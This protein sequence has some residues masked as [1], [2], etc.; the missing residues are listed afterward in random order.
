[1]AAECGGRRASRSVYNASPPSRP[2]PQRARRRVRFFMSREKLAQLVAVTV[3]EIDHELVKRSAQILV[4]AGDESRMQLD[5]LSHRTE[6]ESRI[7]RMH[8][9]VLQNDPVS[10]Q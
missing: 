8:Y 2:D 5:R 1:M 4:R 10:P 6:R 3:L 7:R 9:F